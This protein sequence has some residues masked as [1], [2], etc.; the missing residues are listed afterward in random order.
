VS[1]YLMMFG[2]AQNRARNGVCRILF[3]N[4]YGPQASGL[5]MCQ[6][7]WILGCRPLLSGLLSP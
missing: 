7:S 6:A 1:E 2:G 5:G 4:D 3:A